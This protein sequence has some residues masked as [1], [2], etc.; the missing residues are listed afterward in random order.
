[1]QYQTE[2]STIMPLETRNVAKGTPQTHMPKAKAKHAVVWQPVKAKVTQ[3][4]ATQGKKTRKRKAGDSEEESEEES[5]SNN[6]QPKKK[7]RAKKAVV[8]ESEGESESEVEEIVEVNAL[9]P[10]VEEVVF[11]GDEQPGS[12]E[13]EEVII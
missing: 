2:A 8:L 3:P 9:E 12:D 6:L 1:M 11:I 4:K 13:E 5:D 10:E 7:K